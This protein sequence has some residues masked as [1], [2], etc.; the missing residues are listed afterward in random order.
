MSAQQPQMWFGPVGRIIREVALETGIPADQI[1]GGCR[2][3][4]VFRARSAVCWLA[5]ECTDRSLVRIGLALGGRDHTSVVN[6]IH[7]AEQRRAKGD[8]AFLIMTDRIAARLRE[9]PVIEAA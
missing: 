4:R 9:A 1:I 2:E 7:K 8:P 5:R 3:Q 6:A